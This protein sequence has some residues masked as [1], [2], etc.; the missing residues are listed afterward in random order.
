MSKASS[1]TILSLLRRVADDQ[2]SDGQLLQAFCEHGDEA[3][4]HALLRRHGPM[5][6][7]SISKMQNRGR[8]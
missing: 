7:Q 6:G 4:F 8:Q 2:R 3:C 5:A 1:H